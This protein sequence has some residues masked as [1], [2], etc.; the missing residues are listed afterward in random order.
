MRHAP[1]LTLTIAQGEPGG[2]Y[3]PGNMIDSGENRDVYI[4]VKRNFGNCECAFQGESAPILIIN[5]ERQYAESSQRKSREIILLN[6]L[7][8]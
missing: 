2:I 1:Q 4:T 7:S 3:N 8:I 5:P 6:D